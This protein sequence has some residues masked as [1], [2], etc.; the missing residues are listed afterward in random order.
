MYFRTTFVVLV[1]MTLVVHVA[2]ASAQQLT[3]VPNPSSSDIRSATGQLRH[4]ILGPN[5][6]ILILST[7]AEEISNRPIRIATS[8]DVNLPLVGRLHAAGMT[9][10]QLE[11][12]ILERLKSYI[13]QPDVAII[14]TQYKSQPVSVFGAVGSPG[15]V[16]LEGRKTLLEV[17]SMVGGLKPDAGSRIR[18]TRRNEWGPIPLPSASN[19]GEY[20][21]AEVDIRSIEL[22]SRPGDN[23]EILPNDVITVARAEIVYVMGE[24]KKPG[25]FALNDRTSISIIEAL[26]RAEGFEPTAQAKDATVIRP[27]PGSNRLEIAVNLPDVLRGK[28]RDIMLQPDDILYIPKNYAKGALRQTLNAVVQTA[29]GVIIYRR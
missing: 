2:G 10:E 24:V 13:R 28:A 14:V 26:A 20:S 8:G 21:V 11:T 4:Y 7:H 15:I 29:T 6:E 18:I 22:A 17:L 5:D 27:V 19:E 12:A 9:V 25:G 1:A 23:I 16:Q 3:P